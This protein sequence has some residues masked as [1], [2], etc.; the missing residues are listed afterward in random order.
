MKLLALSLQYH[1]HN[2]A[3]FDGSTLHYHKFERTKQIK[4]FYYDNKWEIFKDVQ[5]LWGFTLD[6]ID[7]IIVDYGAAELFPD[8]EEEYDLTNNKVLTYKIPPKYNIFLKYGIKDIWHINHHYAHSLST[9]MLED[10]SNPPRI[11]VVIDGMGDFKT[12]TV[13]KDEKIIKNIYEQDAGS[14]GFQMNNAGIWLG[15]NTESSLDNAGKVMGLQSYGDLHPRYLEESQQF[16]MENINGLFDLTRW[17]HYMNDPLLTKLTPLDWIRTVHTR[18]EEVLVDFFSQYCLKDEP[19]SYSGGVAQNVVWN[20]KLAL[21]FK[22]LII[23]PHSSDEGTSLGAIEWLRKQHNL[24]KFSMLNFP[25]IQSDTAPTTEPTDETIAKVAQLLSKNKIVAWYQGNGEVGPRALGHRSILM[26]PSIPNGK[27]IINSVKRRENY[28]PFG[29]SVLSEHVLDYFEYDLKD[30]YMLLTNNF[31]V[32]DF[33][34]I[35]HVDGTCRVQTVENDA[36]SFR[37]LLEKFYE[38]TGH[39]ILL[40]TSLNV[41]RKPIAGYP[42]NAID[43]LHET[44]VDCVVIGNEIITK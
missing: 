15:I 19:I 25:Y 1:D 43:I 37:F 28:R 3:Y 33:P 11:R 42:E 2:A 44:E 5:D 21:K 17:N 4:H 9:W 32:T 7:D 30:P 8:V 16:N 23:P 6:E 40:N 14:I 35:T 22:N 20:T 13:F 29:A 27:N 10:E 34:A 31:K 36:S 18:I 39:A 12:C 24:P 26:N 41:N 38:L